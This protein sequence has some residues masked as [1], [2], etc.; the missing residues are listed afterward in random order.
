MDELQ[1][2]FRCCVSLT[3]YVRTYLFCELLGQ[4]CDGVK[5]IG[6]HV[7]SR[8]E[9]RTQAGDTVREMPGS[10]GRAS[11]CAEWG[12]QVVGGGRNDV[13]LFETVVVRCSN[14]LTTSDLCR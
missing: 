8:V 11:S 14:G 13:S 2:R 1:V 6:F 7:R 9:S 3:T 5:P 10:V 4:I 12:V